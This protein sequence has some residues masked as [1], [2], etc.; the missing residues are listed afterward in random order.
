[1]DY[2]IT[3]T[4][5]DDGSK[6]DVQLKDKLSNTYPS[7][8][9]VRLVIYTRNVVS[10]IINLVTGRYQGKLG[11]VSYGTNMLSAGY[12]TVKVLSLDSRY[13]F[14]AS[15]KLYIKPVATLKKKTY[16]TISNGVR[17]QVG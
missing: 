16:M 7:G 15:C 1:M 8:V 13:S 14:G 11:Y 10:K 2:S 4:P 17:H 12:H 6:I 5:Y 3:T 9:K